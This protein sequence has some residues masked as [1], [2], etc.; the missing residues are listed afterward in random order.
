MMGMVVIAGAMVFVT[1]VGLL[2]KKWKN[3]IK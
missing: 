1:A 3:R 2:Y